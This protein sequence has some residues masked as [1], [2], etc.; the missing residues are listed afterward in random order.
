MLKQTI[1]SE[2]HTYEQA[3]PLSLQKEKLEEKNFQSIPAGSG[4]E[5][6]RVADSN[7]KCNDYYPSTIRILKIYKFTLA[8]IFSIYFQRASMADLDPT[9]L[10]LIKIN[11]EPSP[12]KGAKYSISNR[13]GAHLC[14]LPPLQGL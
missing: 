12:N 9:S 10:V 14:P 6:D 3:L 7:L 4:P 13:N 2:I 8:Q 11:I 1:S 5:Q